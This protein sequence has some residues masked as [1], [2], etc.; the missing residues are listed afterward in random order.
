MP[1]FPPCVGPSSTWVRTNFQ[2][3]FRALA[4]SRHVMNRHQTETAVGLKEAWIRRSG[5]LEISQGQVGLEPGRHGAAAWCQGQKSIFEAEGQAQGWRTLLPRAG[6]GRA[7]SRG[8]E[9]EAVTRGTPRGLF[10]GMS[11]RTLAASSQGPHPGLLELPPSPPS[12]QGSQP[13]P[14]DQRSVAVIH[15]LQIIVLCV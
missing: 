12:V 9:V 11:S 15:P 14:G 2:K 4:V 1:Q 3:P 5:W 8:C 7:G 6:P 13:H 10:V